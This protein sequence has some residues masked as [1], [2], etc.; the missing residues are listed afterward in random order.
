[1]R[2]LLKWLSVTSR[3]CNRYLDKRLSKYEIS[4][5][6]YFYILRICENPGITQDSL[7]QSVYISPSNITR[8]LAQLEKSDFLTRSQSLQDKRTYHLYPTQKARQYYE[9]IA[10]AAI[11]CGEQLLS[12]FS[13]TERELFLSMLQKAACTAIAMNE[14]EEEE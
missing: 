13:D 4:S 10:Q 5:S 6:Q 2:E 9:E 1:M 8:A 7:F 14:N 11:S 12:T 3:Y